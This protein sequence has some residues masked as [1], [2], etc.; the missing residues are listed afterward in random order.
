MSQEKKTYE[1]QL[2]RIVREYRV[3]QV[4]AESVSAARIRARKL[5]HYEAELLP[6]EDTGNWCDSEVSDYHRVHRVEEKR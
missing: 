5:S 1:V 3:I 6:G 2:S 4:R